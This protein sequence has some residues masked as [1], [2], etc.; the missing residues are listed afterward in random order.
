MR[1]Q[2][3]ALAGVMALIVFTAITA[4]VFAQE[5][6]RD[7]GQVRIALAEKYLFDFYKKSK[8]ARNTAGIVGIGGGALAG[9]ASRPYPSSRRLHR[10]KHLNG[11]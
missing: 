2:Q 1:Q 5:K 3:R 4:S 8:S 10:G 11:I 6:A 9:D 7:E